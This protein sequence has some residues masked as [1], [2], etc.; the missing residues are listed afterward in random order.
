MKFITPQNV[1]SKGFEK[2]KYMKHK[3]IKAILVGFLA[4][5]GSTFLGL[6]YLPSGIFKI[7][8]FGSSSPLGNALALS[9]YFTI[10]LA[11][12]GFMEYKSNWLKEIG[13][14][15]LLGIISAFIINELAV[16][17]FSHMNLTM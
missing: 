7:F 2:N 5:F 14:L 15:L 8:F 3:L 17:I 16:Y 1:V 9:I 10:L 12:P 13:T 11:I 6:N 4:T